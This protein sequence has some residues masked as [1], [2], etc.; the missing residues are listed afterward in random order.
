MRVIRKINRGLVL[1]LII[2]AVLA[3]YLTV[4]ELSR[5]S[6]K[7]EIKEVCK[8]AADL[9][10]QCIIIPPELYAYTE[11]YSEEAFQKYKEECYNKLAPMCGET[12]T[13]RSMLEYALETQRYTNNYITN[14]G[15][16]SIENIEYFF[17]KDTVSV[18]INTSLNYK[19]IY[20]GLEES[21][22]SGTLMATPCFTFMLQK[23]DG[24]WKLLAFDPDLSAY[25]AGGFDNYNSYYGGFY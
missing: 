13:V 18:S 8:Q 22:N 1:F 19:S 17:D 7:A 5:D 4:L 12:N 23:E 25:P 15:Q 2:V 6:Q 10:S 24:Q 3:T 20:G 11:T 9:Y 14:F 16:A 21:A